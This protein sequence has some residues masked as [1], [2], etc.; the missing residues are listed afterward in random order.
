MTLFEHLDPKDV[1][2]LHTV[3]SERALGPGD[4]LVDRG[5][6]LEAIYV[7][8][9]G[10]LSTSPGYRPGVPFSPGDIIGEFSFLDGHP[11]SAVVTAVENSRLLRIA[12]DDISETIR[13]DP[14]FGVRFYKALGW[15]VTTRLRQVLEQL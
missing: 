14:A 10:L 9:S 6:D 15:I 13:V 11:A 2:W 8:L 7:V 12:R 4:S 3:G 1:E 5:E